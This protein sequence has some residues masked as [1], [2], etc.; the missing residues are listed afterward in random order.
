M[1][2]RTP[3]CL[4]LVFLGVAAS[5]LLTRC[6]SVVNDEDI[7]QVVTV[8]ASL[9]TTGVQGDQDVNNELPDVSDDGRFVVFCSK[10]S[11]FV[12]LDTN[13]GTPKFDVFR[14]DMVA[15]VTTL[16]SASYNV[17]PG[18][19][20]SSNG[21]STSPTISGDGRYVCF[22]STGTDLHVDDGDTTSD[23]YVR[24]MD[25]GITYL[26]SRSTG[27][28]GPK[29]LS[30]SRNAHFSQGGQ[31]IVFESNSEELDG[32]PA[33]GPDTDPATTIY[34]RQFLDSLG[35][36]HPNPST[37]VVSTT[38][39]GL[40]PAGNCENPTV[41]ADGNFVCFQTI[42]D[43]L[44]GP[45]EGGPDASTF[46]DVFLK[47]M[48]TGTLQRVSVAYAAVDPD[49]ACE[50]AMISDDGS[51]IIFK[52]VASN[53]VPEDLDPASDMMLADVL[54]GAMQVAT[55]HTSGSQAGAGCTGPTISSDGRRVVFHSPSTNLI[56]GDTNGQVVDIFQHDFATGET[57]RL[58]VSTF[59][60][61]LAQ[62]SEWAIIAGNGDYVVYTSLA[63]T[64]VD[65]DTNAKRD[66]Y[67]RGPAR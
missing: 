1:V 3:F 9:A 4:G 26:V 13:G 55:V 39:G 63:T 52:S 66:I 42:V 2:R 46:T 8:R 57:I 29:G 40:E 35:D 41:S 58:S 37:E 12:P 22:Q 16:V 64:I 25:L 14:R 31:W 56:N 53:L 19:P 5:G 44:V 59:G 43:G 36:P 7:I 24:D 54:T 51:S 28:A 47:H 10:A 48:V 30:A 18:G 32:T 50:T 27:A 45:T 15:R 33:G 62:N 11:T 65:D 60:A 38:T 23:L 49:G 61:E 67:V 21:E 6:D 20:D 34:R 17:V